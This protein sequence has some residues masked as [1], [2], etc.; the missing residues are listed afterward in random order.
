MTE[1]TTDS[2]DTEVTDLR[3]NGGHADTLAFTLN[4]AEHARRQTAGL[5]ALDRYTWIEPLMTLPQGCPVPLDAINPALHPTLRRIPEGVFEPGRPDYLRLAIPPASNFT[6]YVKA[7][8]WAPGHLARASAFAPV[9]QRAIVLASTAKPP[10]AMA[11]SEA[12]FWG[13]GVGRITDSGGF[14]WLLAPAPYRPVRFTAARWR[15]AELVYGAWLT[16]QYAMRRLSVS[17]R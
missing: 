2:L 13:I 10:G 15:F 5:H 14:E 1:S 7:K 11:L 17:Q 3:W 12:D 8:R 4:T 6:A 9:G 16:D